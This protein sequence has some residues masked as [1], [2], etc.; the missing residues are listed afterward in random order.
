MEKKLE[1]DTAKIPDK[2]VGYHPLKRYNRN[3]RKHQGRSPLPFTPSS[4]PQMPLSLTTKRRSDLSEAFN[5][6][7]EPSHDP[8]NSEEER[9]QAGISMWPDED[10][11][12]L[13]G[14][15]A[16]LMAYHTELLAF[17]RKL[18]GIFALALGMD[19]HYFDK[20]TRRPE[21]GMRV[22][23]YPEQEVEAGEQN[24]IGACLLLPTCPL[25]FTSPAN[26]I[27]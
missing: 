9:Q 6:A 25:G 21:A 2:Y 19:E 24:G 10:G 15:K 5:W 8:L 23:H 20:Y 27:G 3:Q 22:I 26:P 4:A 7:Y 13:L 11:C 14:F 12:E 17:A 18:T 1:V 16:D